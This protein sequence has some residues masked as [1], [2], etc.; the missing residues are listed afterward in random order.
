MAI[1]LS[2][3]LAELL[4]LWYSVADPGG[5][6]LGAK[7]TPGG[8]LNARLCPELATFQWGSARSMRTQPDA[9]VCHVRSSAGLRTEV[10]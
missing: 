7:R 9:C 3:I 8:E 1:L 4:W 2:D 10:P 6:R 5:Q